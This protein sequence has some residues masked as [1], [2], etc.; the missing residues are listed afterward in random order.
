MLNY[1]NELFELA[2]IK[3]EIEFINKAKYVERF[4]KMKKL[5]KD[6]FNELDIQSIIES[7]SVKKASS[8][9]MLGRY[10]FFKT[11]ENNDL[12]NKIESSQSPN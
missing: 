4:E 9:I 7:E 1:K 10:L 5:L 6:H 2:K 3:I 11:Y 12:K 8:N